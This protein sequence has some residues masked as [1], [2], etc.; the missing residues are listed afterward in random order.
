MASEDSNTEYDLVVIGGGSGGVRASRIAAGHG[1]KVA[2]IEGQLNHGAPN[3]SAI[4]GTC[5]NVGCVP[6]KLMV[7]AARYPAEVGEA[8]GYGWQGATPGSFDWKQFM[9]Y[10]D[11]EI[12][13]LNNVYNN[14]VLGKAGVEVIEGLGKLDGKNKVEVALAGGGTKTL[15][16]KNILVAVG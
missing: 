12:T 3:Y 2:L 7:F 6:K 11:K 15:A 14:F 4:G 16:T 9:E 13:R 5:V 8:G 10:K 1:A